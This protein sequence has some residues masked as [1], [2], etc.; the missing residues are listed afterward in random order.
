[1]RSGAAENRL[2]VVLDSNVLVSAFVFLSGVPYQILQRLLLG[3]ILVGASPFI[4]S[5]VEKVLRDKF[6]VPEETISEALSILRERC[7]LVDPPVVAANPDLSLADNRILDCAVASRAHY[8]ITGDKGI[9]RLGEFHGIRIVSPAK[10][11]EVVLH[12]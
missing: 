2:R 3:E 5:E 11:Y 4:L 6:H 7:T 12:D 10:F 1:M 8:L 9:Q